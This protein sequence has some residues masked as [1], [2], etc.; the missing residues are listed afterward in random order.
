MKVRITSPAE[1][2][3]ADAAAYYEIAEDGLAEKFINSINAAL[4]KIKKHPAIGKP[5]R[6]NIRSIATHKFPYNIVY[7]VHKNEILI[8]AI[9]HQSRLP[10]YWVDR[11]STNAEDQEQ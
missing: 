10:D 2:E 9:A 4:S 5:R 7:E 8:H 6:T 3:F 11:I 1:A